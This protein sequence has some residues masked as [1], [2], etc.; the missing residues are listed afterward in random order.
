MLCLFLTEKAF[1][2]WAPR[3][4]GSKEGMTLRAC[5]CQQAL[6]QLLVLLCQLPPCSPLSQ[7]CE[8][9]AEEHSAGLNF[10]EIN[11]GAA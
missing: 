2:P 10:Q 8:A 1:I 9:S 4:P 6:P 3:E 11:N 7:L 5:S